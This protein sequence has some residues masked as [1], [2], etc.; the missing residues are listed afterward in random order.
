M[1]I[2]TGSPRRIIGAPDVL[3]LSLTGSTPCVPPVPSK[4]PSRAVVPSGVMATA[5]KLPEIVV[6]S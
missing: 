3:A 1:A 4:K 6:P 2:A 5:V